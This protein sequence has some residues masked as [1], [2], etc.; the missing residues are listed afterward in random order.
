MPLF[1]LIAVVLFVG[2]TLRAWGWLVDANAYD[3]L[4]LIASGLALWCLSTLNIPS[5]PG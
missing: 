3:A 4:G 5:P 2:G 1:R